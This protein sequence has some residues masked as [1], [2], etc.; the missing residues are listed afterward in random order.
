MRF[1]EQSD[2]GDRGEDG[3]AGQHDK[4]QTPGAEGQNFSPKRGRDQ[5]R[6]A[7]YDRNRGELQASLAALKQVADDRPRQNADRSGARS[8]HQAKGEQR[9]DRG[10]ESRAR[11]A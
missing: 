6:N 4:N 1:L 3:H 8:L 7:E 2:G 11:G 5:R 9:M 10:G